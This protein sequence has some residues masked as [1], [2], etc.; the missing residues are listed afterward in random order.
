MN[1]AWVRGIVIF[2]F[3]F[4]SLATFATRAGA[5][6]NDLA[7]KFGVGLFKTVIK[8][9]STLDDMGGVSAQYHFTD[10]FALQGGYDMEGDVKGPILR[11]LFFADPVSI[12]RAY[13]GFGY[14]WQKADVWGNNWNF[15]GPLVTG[16]FLFDITP[17][18]KIGAEG[19]YSITKV[20]INSREAPQQTHW[21]VVASAIFLFGDKK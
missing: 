13:G 18:I 11:A 17:N 9:Q 21:F 6:E 7:G 16:G 15:S 19:D 10:N 4:V 3:S 8:D 5:G 20:T 1:T 2:F 14:F 12:G